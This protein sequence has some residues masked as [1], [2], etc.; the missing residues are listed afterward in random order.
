MEPKPSPPPPPA[1]TSAAQSNAELVSLV[2]ALKLDFKKLRDEY[3][4][5]IDTLMA[6]LD[7]ERKKVRAL[8][9]DIDRLKK[10]SAREN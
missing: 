6:D 2:E 9:I 10:R 4:H 3:R 1:S 7:Q 5:D 8:E